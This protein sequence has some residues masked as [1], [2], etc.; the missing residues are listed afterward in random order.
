MKASATFLTFHF[1]LSA[2]CWSSFEH[3]VALMF[4]SER[5]SRYS[6]TAVDDQVV[7]VFMHFS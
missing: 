4:A 7:N 6:M 2:K 3:V 1:D 5:D